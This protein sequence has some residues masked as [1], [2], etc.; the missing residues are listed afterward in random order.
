MLRSFPQ[1]ASLARG[2]LNKDTTMAIW[3][4]NNPLA[5]SLNLTTFAKDEFDKLGIWPLGNREEK[6][7]NP[8]GNLIVY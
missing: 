8:P 2:D 1:P 7:Y 5:L 4:L 3:S 6:G